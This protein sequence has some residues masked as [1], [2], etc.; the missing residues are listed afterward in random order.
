MYKTYNDFRDYKRELIVSTD[1]STRIEKKFFDKTIL[2][3]P[4]SDTW[5]LH[6][7]VT[8]KCNAKCNF[9]IEKGF[10]GKEYEKEYLDAV[11]IIV[12]EM[13]NQKILSS[14]SITGGEPT[15]FE[16]FDELVD[17]A[18]VSPFLTLNTNGSRLYNHFD[19]LKKFDFINVSRHHFDDRKNAAIFDTKVLNI[20]QLRDIKDRTG[21]KM[22]IQTVVLD[23]FPLDK[24][25]DH[26]SFADDLS[27]RKL[28]SIGEMHN[29]VYSNQ[30]SNNAYN[31]LMD[32]IRSRSIFKSQT[33]QDYYMY[34]TWKYRGKE[35]TLSYSDMK[36]LEYL[37]SKEPENVCREFILHPNLILSG[38]WNSNNKII[39]KFK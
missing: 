33:I 4:I 17:I 25:M 37:E 14:I 23:E 7:K 29:V 12:Q 36:A 26:Y 1:N 9:C 21:V 24:H 2:V 15:L 16:R 5:H 32:I 18:R 19:S 31:R 38:S 3:E 8:N 22:R 34:E 10:N 20:F 11:N 6:L 39:S 35:L 13:F 28:M 30:A 27:F